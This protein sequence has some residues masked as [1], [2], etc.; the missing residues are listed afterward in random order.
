MDLFRRYE[1]TTDSQ[2]SQSLSS[3]W[4][5]ALIVTLLV[6]FALVIG[7]VVWHSRRT[8]RRRWQA[9]IR[10]AEALATN[11]EMRQTTVT[12]PPPPEYSFPDASI[13]KPPPVLSAK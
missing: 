13:Q 6:L 5:I 7:T 11:G 2:E 4:Q 12:P 10:D 9:R 3:S 1:T 8:R